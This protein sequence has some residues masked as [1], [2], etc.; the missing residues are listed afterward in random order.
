MVDQSHVSLVEKAV[1]I[2]ESSHLPSV[3]KKL[4][5]GRL[6]FVAEPMLSMFVEVCEEDPFGIDLVVKNLKRKLDTQG[7]LSKLHQVIEEE[8]K[9]VEEL[10]LANK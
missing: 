2:I 10:I 3:D 9:E 1:A 4:I 6:P 8:R 7:N 5:K